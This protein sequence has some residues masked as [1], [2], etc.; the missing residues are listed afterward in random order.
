MSFSD[1]GKFRK[2]R[3][4]AVR[5][6]YRTIRVHDETALDR[7][8]HRVKLS[9]DIILEV[10]PRGQLVLREK[11]KRTRYYTTVANVFSGLV[12]RSAMVGAAAKKKN[13]KRSRK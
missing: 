5:K 11:G 1:S 6:P 9:A 4:P 10:H 12:W 13:R 8:H 2:P 3:K 7:G